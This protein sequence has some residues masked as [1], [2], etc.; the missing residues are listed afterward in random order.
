[1][2]VDKSP[3]RLETCGPTR[4]C[5]NGVSILFWSCYACNNSA[6]TIKTSPGRSITVFPHWTLVHSHTPTLQITRG[7]KKSKNFL[8]GSGIMRDRLM[9]VDK[10]PMR[11]ETCGPTRTCLNGVSRLFWVVMPVTTLLTPSRQVLVGP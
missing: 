3:M 6:Y 5:L 4:T 9:Q 7:V 8:G 11:L 2:Q 10:S 1:M